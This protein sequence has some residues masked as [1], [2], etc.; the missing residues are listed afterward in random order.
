[1]ETDPVYQRRHWIC[2]NYVAAPVDVLVAVVVAVVL[3]GVLWR[4]FSICTHSRCCKW[5]LA[6]ES[7]C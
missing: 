1:M 2:L 4:Y 6:S 5:E 7:L 3:F